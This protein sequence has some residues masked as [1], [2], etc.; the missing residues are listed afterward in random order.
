MLHVLEPLPELNIAV[1]VPF[2]VY[3]VQSASDVS[4][5]LLA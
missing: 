1:A 4:G 3:Y 5:L 2:S